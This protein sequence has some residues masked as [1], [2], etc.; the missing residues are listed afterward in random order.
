MLPSPTRP[1]R[2]EPSVARR[3]R[4]CRVWLVR[5]FT[6]AVLLLAALPAWA[7]EFAALVAGLGGDGFAEKE[8]AVHALGRLG[9]ARAIPVLTGLRDGRLEKAPDGRMIIAGAPKA[10]DAVSGAE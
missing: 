8:Q 6:F 5:L 9:D 3:G 10:I 4:G 1:W 2:A 7:D